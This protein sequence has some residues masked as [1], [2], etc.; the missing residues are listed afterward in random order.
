M[1]E[2][3]EALVRSI[4]DGQVALDDASEEFA[5]QAVINPILSHLGWNT[6]NI[7]EVFPE[8]P[9]EGKRVDYCL[10]LHGSAQVLIEAKKAAENLEQHERQLLE[11]SFGQGVPLAVLT[12]GV[13]WWFYL[14]LKKG[15]WRERK[16]FAVDIAS[17]EPIAAAQHLTEFLSKVAVTDGSAERLANEVLN[18]NVRQQKTSEALPRIWAELM[19]L[20][21]DLPNELF[22]LIFQRVESACG[23]QPSRQQVM[24]YLSLATAPGIHIGISLTD[25]SK[26]GR[27]T[28]ILH[29]GKWHYAAE[30][31]EKLG[32]QSINAVL[33]SLEQDGAVEL[34]KDGKGNKVRLRQR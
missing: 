2:S 5:R 23:Y 16:F 8:F 13:M 10:K 31:R 4:H 3:L 25:T 20:P 18:D 24:D 27:V 26:A 29:D 30:L 1:A 21:D 12:N 11:Y 9:I 32:T 33:R 14:P 28:E 15:P 22:D 7:E 34:M 6:E 19:A 17:Q